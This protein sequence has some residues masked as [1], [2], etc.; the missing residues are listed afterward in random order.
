MTDARGKLTIED[1]A[2]E[3]AEG[4]IDTVD[5]AF[6]DLYGRLVGKRYDASFFLEEVPTGGAHACDYLLT[7]D[8]GMEPVPGYELTNWETG[9]GDLHLQPDMNTLRRITWRERTALVLCDVVH[10]DAQWT[11]LWPGTRSSLPSVMRRV[12][13]ARKSTTR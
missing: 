3:V 6:T 2:R 1:L 4:N 8:M 12:K 7:V 9:Y 11:Q 13:S 10:C 5:V